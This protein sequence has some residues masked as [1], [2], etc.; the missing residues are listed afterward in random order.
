MSSKKLKGWHTRTLAYP[1]PD[2]HSF[3]PLQAD[4]ELAMLS[5][6]LEDPDGFVLAIFSSK[7]DGNDQY[8]VVDALGRVLLLPGTSTDIKG[9][10]GLGRKV[11]GLP[12]PGGP[13]NSWT[14]S[15]KGTCQTVLK[16]L[17]ASGSSRGRCWLNR[18]FMGKRKLKATSVYGYRQGMT[19]LTMKINGCTHLPDMIYKLFG[20]LLEGYQGPGTVDRFVIDRVKGVLQYLNHL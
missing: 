2:P 9:L 18:L 11:S 7:D 19:K 16:L 6:S 13:G 14:I 20:L 15:H 12:P 17:F 1:H 10:L 5:S 4:L 3:T 8:V